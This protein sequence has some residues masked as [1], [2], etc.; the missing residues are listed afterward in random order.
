MIV[1]NKVDTFHIST[2]NYACLHI[3]NHLSALQS[4]IVDASL[5]NGECSKLDNKLCLISISPIS[6]GANNFA[7]AFN[8]KTTVGDGLG[9]ELYECNMFWVKNIGVVRMIQHTAQPDT[10]D[11]V[12]W[13]VVQ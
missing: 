5:S 2:Q 13:N 10:L 6:I 11:I 1:V 12:S 4:N 3:S 7:E 8:I 9:N